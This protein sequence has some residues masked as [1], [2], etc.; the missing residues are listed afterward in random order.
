MKPIRSLTTVLLVGSVFP[1]LIGSAF[2]R[3]QTLACPDALSTVEMSLCVGKLL[4]QKDKQLSI[5][6]QKVAA[7]AAA[8]PGGQFPTIWKDSLTGFFKTS[9]DPEDQV[10][11]FQQA[12]RNACVFMNSLAVQGT[13]FG[14]FVSNCEIRLTDALLQSL[15]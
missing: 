8:V 10:A 4:E 14:I 12:R 9:A 3:A 1:S 6:M 5:A 11:A 15:N 13:G 2:A 7:D